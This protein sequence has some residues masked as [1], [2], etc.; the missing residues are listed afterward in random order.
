MR[1]IFLMRSL[2]FLYSKSSSFSAHNPNYKTPSLVSFAFHN[3]YTSKSESSSENPLT[4]Q[5]ENKTQ[6]EIPVDAEDVSS[7]DLKTQIDKF[8]KGDFEAIPTIFESI[9]KRKLSGKHEE[10]D[11]E[12]M[13]EFREYQTNEVSDEELD[14]DSYSDTDSDS[15]G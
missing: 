14:S 12:L 9:L 6:N 4:H 7:E 2:N 8:Y 10:S 13:N 1:K 5:S 11:D 15:D 3:L